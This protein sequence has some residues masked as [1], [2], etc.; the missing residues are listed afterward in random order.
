MN[1]SRAERSL[2][3][4][5]SEGG[6]LVNVVGSVN[7]QVFAFGHVGWFVAAGRVYF[8][9]EGFAGSGSLVKCDVPDAALPF[10]P[11]FGGNILFNVVVGVPGFGD[12]GARHR[13]VV[14]ADDGVG[15]C[16]WV[17]CE[18]VAGSIPVEPSR[19]T[20]RLI[21]SLHDALFNAWGDGGRVGGV[22]VGEVAHGAFPAFSL[23]WSCYFVCLRILIVARCRRACL[24]FRAFS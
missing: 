14:Q 1:G 21:D 22:L 2:E 5:L 6:F 4:E 17:A 10:A 20:P 19:A 3:S 8:T 11:T 15:A 13:V 12:D 18:P 16:L 24:W 7:D 9:D 23:G